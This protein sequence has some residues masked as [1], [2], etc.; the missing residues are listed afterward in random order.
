[1]DATKPESVVNLTGSRVGVLAAS[2]AFLV[3][4]V[5]LLAA[6]LASAPDARVGPMLAA[7]IA[8]GYLYQGPPFRWAWR[9]QCLL[10]ADPQ[11]AGPCRQPGSHGRG[12]RGRRRPQPPL[13]R[14]SPCALPAPCRFSYKGLGEL[15]CFWAFGPLATVAFYL[16]L[17]PAAGSAAAAAGGGLAVPAHVWVLSVLVGITTTVILFCSHFHQIE[18]DKAAG[19]LSPLVRLGTETACKVGGSGA[20]LLEAIRQSPASH[21]RAARCAAAVA[22]GATACCG[23]QAQA[24]RMVALT[25][26]APRSACRCS[27][28][29]PGCLTSSRWPPALPGRCP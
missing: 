12:M 25:T 23:H 5:A 28:R 2:L 24:T 13:P 9:T 21:R 4:G 29:P 8:C 7:A 20:R 14:S 6:Q 10:Q 26:H 22:A 15:L 18:G 19:K 11:E 16:A 3:A 27:R 1:M 17:L